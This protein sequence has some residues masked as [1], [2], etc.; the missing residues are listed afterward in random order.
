MKHEK[1]IC[2][3]CATILLASCKPPIHYIPIES[4]RTEYTNNYRRDSVY[5]HDSAL[6]KMKNDTVY[7]EKYKTVYRDRLLRDSVFIRDSIQAPY[8]VE[9][10]REVNKPTGWQNFLMWCG[11]I[12]CLLFAGTI[13]YKL[14]KAKIIH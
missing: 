9:V 2:T 1:R 8:P 14:F 5:L 13:G 7:F 11:G 10:L 4:Q 12:A 3:I 6:I